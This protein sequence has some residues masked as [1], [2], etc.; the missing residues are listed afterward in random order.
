MI[1]NFLSIAVGLGTDEHNSGL[2]VTTQNI[3]TFE[4]PVVPENQASIQELISPNGLLHLKVP[5]F[6]T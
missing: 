4:P 6:R 3:Q 2:E 5:L 1:T